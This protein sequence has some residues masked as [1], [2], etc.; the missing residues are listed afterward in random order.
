MPAP[1]PAMIPA[2]SSTMTMPPSPMEPGEA[3]SA[4][5]MAAALVTMDHFRAL[6][7]SPDRLR[8]VASDPLTRQFL[9]ERVTAPEVVS[10]TG[11]SADYLRWLFDTLISSGD[12]IGADAVVPNFRLLAPEKAPSWPRIWARSFAPYRDRLAPAS[13]GAPAAY[14][15]AETL[16]AWRAY[17]TTQGHDSPFGWVYPRYTQH[18]E[19]R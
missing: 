10:A 15:G 9:L 4:D 14:R 8:Q 7:S 12:R 1:Q 16:I 3:A 17:P 13:A 6:V 5:Q 11:L 19:S 2:P 18:L